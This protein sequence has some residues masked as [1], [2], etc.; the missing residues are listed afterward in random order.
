VRIGAELGAQLR[1]AGG[2]EKKRSG[3]HTAIVAAWPSASG[4]VT[5]VTTGADLA[6]AD[7]ENL[8]A[9]EASVKPHRLC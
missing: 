5:T 1:G 3:Q 7:Q 8:T 6:L 4:V 2:I 9:A